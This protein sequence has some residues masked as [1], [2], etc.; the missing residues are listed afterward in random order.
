MYVSVWSL[1]S[2]L[3]CAF[4]VVA[5]HTS[6]VSSTL[7]TPGCRNVRSFLSAFFARGSR[8]FFAVLSNENMLQLE[9]SS[10]YSRRLVQATQHPQ[11]AG[12]PTRLVPLYSVQIDSSTS[13]LSPN[14]YGNGG[15]WDMAEATADF[16]KSMSSCSERG[17]R[18]VCREVAA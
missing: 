2:Q 13:T 9:P 4:V 5:S 12:Q 8:L 18:E 14:V 15:P 3:Q 16:R 17:R 7:M 10:Y 1:D 6:T 11:P